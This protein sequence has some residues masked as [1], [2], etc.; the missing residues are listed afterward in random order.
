MVHRHFVLVLFV[1]FLA[2]LPASSQ[3]PQSGPAPRTAVPSQVSPAPQAAPRP[4]D[5]EVAPIRC[6]WKTDNAAIRIG[7]RFT[8]TLTCGVVETSRLTVVANT[9]LPCVLVAAFGSPVVPD[10]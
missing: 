9:T 3:T 7:E 1:I 5:V 2:A 8:L 10:V 4:D 6:W